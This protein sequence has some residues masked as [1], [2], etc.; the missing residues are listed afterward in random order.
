[1]RIVY[2]ARYFISIV[3]LLTIIYGGFRLLGHQLRALD[4]SFTSD[5]SK[6]TQPCNLMD[7]IKLKLG[8]TLVRFPAK[9][10]FRIYEAKGL[11]KFPRRQLEEEGLFFQ[12]CDD[13]KPHHFASALSRRINFLPPVEPLDEGKQRTGPIF[14]YMRMSVNRPHFM[15][16][17]IYDTKYIQ[18]NAD[19]S[20]RKDFTERTGYKSDVSKCF[21]LEKTGYESCLVYRYLEDINL[22]ISA[23]LV[24][25]DVN[26][27]GNSVYGGRQPSREHWPAL[28]DSEEK[29]WRNIVVEINNRNPPY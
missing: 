25:S 4:F 21:V 7:P 26:V 12:M 2:T 23:L 1:M 20:R 29:Y 27:Y 14:V 6:L 15:K 16:N 19:G 10:N 11:P 24:P 18:L 13:N 17:N 3:L 5:R 28:M 22:T 8:D 9:N